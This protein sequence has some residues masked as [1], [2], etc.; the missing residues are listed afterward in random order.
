MQYSNH[1][2]SRVAIYELK[3]PDLI[4]ILG[5][6]KQQYVYIHSHKKTWAAGAHTARTRMRQI[7]HQLVVERK[8]IMAQKAEQIDA[9]WS[10]VY[11]QINNIESQLQPE[12]WKPIQNWND[13]VEYYNKLLPSQNEDVALPGTATI[14]ELSNIINY[15]LTISAAKSLK[16]FRNE[17]FQQYIERLYA[18]GAIS[19][20]EKQDL[21]LNKINVKALF[22]NVEDFLQTKS[23]DFRRAFIS[24]KAVSEYITS[25]GD[26][27]KTKQKYNTVEKQLDFIPDA[28]VLGLI[29][30]KA[31]RSSNKKG[32][33]KLET[34]IIDSFDE[35][36]FN[37]IRQ[38]N[39]STIHNPTLIT[40][41][42]AG[43]GHSQKGG[44]NTG[45]HKADL[46]RVIP[47]G[48]ISIQIPTSVKLSMAIKQ[49]NISNNQVVIEAEDLFSSSA[50]A[51]YLNF[52]ELNE[53]V[54]SNSYRKNAAEI[55]ALSR[56]VYTNASALDEAET[57]QYYG[58]FNKAIIQYLAWLKLDTQII[59]NPDNAQQLVMALESINSIH[60]AADLLRQMIK[61]SPAGIE[62]YIVVT[63]NPLQQVKRKSEA[64]TDALLTDIDQKISEMWNSYL[65][66]VSEKPNF[67]NIYSEVVSVL[68]NYSTITQQLL[69]T[70]SLYYKIA[71]RNKRA[72]TLS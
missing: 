59:G 58:Y 53:S 68:Q 17:N 4:Y 20:E 39:G 44:L 25:L 62:K 6:K 50:S 49:V 37:I 5:G 46:V 32:I 12:T 45:I 26:T 69:P 48:S 33:D 31:L 11:Q 52:E 14:K 2:V 27:A 21:E 36:V 24:S 70:V 18:F 8:E 61:V 7:L 19:K 29:T 1:S 57:A 13:F 9:L 22:T 40:T 42:V 10:E 47:Y 34:Q 64:T 15:K 16:K 43:E 35:N 65:K 54:K 67:R 60:N 66:K 72:L 41:S 51:K 56:Y 55:T 3:D 63:N 23:E 38:T 28:K 71:L 30:E